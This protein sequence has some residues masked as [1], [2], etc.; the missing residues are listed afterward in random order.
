VKGK[1]DVKREKGKGGDADVGPAQGKI[2]SDD[3]EII[4]S[5]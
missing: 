5:K 1:K 4:E 2:S 3:K